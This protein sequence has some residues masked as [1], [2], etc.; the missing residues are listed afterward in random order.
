MFG[1]D[2][3]GLALAQSMLTLMDCSEFSGRDVRELSR[4]ER[5]RVAIATALAQAAPLV[6]MDEPT[7]HQDPRHQALVLSRLAAL[8]GRSFVAAIHD[9]N[10]ASHFATHVLLLDGAGHWRAGPVAEV[11]TAAHLSELFETEVREVGAKGESVFVTRW[12]G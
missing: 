10:A 12:P 4:G 3:D 9:L 1:A 11:L 6:L 5:Q 8:S 7:A 2:A